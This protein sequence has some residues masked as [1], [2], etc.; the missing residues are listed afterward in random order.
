M[1]SFPDVR[2]RIWIADP[3]V[4]R[5]APVHEDFC[6]S[7]YPTV[8]TNDSELHELTYAEASALFFK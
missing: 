5:K 6:Q 8:T 2:D 3:P 4:N 1:I 7:G